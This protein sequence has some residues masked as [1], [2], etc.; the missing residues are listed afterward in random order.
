MRQFQRGQD[1][2]DAVIEHL[3]RFAADP[4]TFAAEYGRLTGYCCFCHL[5]LKSERSVAVG[6]G[7]VCARNYRLPWGKAKS[8]DPISS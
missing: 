7:P 3:K 8:A 6:Y 4:A 5:T 2:S 1:C